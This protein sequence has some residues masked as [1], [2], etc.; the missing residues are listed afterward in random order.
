MC[1]GCG[2][3]FTDER[4]K[5]VEPAGRGTPRDR[6]PHL[7]DACKQRAITAE[8]QAALAGPEHQEHGQAVPEQKAGGTWLSRFRG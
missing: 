2:I 5:A 6:H 1:A 4:W 8:R 7:C 3:R